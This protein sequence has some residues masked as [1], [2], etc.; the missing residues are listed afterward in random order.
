ML[1]LLLAGALGGLV[2]GIVGF[3]KYQFAYKNVQ[4]KPTYV[5]TLMAISAFVGLT[6][7]WSIVESGISS[8]FL[9]DI[10]PAI[11]FIVG[12]AGGD[13]VENLYKILINRTTL[14]PLPQK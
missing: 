5:A 12:Y 10:N 2:R 4:F 1:S 8:P 13:L 9:S 7:T 6:V 11:A 14:Y 3:V